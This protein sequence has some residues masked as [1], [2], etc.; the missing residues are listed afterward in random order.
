MDSTRAKL[1]RTLSDF[2]YGGDG[3]SHGELDQVFDDFD[4]EVAGGSKRDRVR[5]AV[6]VCPESVL[7]RLVAGLVD[8]LNR[9]GLLT[10]PGADSAAVARLQKRLLPYNLRIAEDGELVGGTRLGIEPEAMIDVPALREHIAR[11]HL[12]LETD[13]SALMLGSSKELL[14]STGKL[15]LAGV[16]EEPPAKFPGLL[17]RALEVLGL[18]AKAT[19]GDDDVAAATRKILGGLQQIG[20]GVNELRN[21]H[22]TG[23]GRAN[24]VKLGLRQSRLAAGS[25]V[26]LASVMID[27]LE[28]PNAPW[29]KKSAET[30]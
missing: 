27:T 11:I 29:R 1:A 9:L 14:E 18:H 15:V 28:D 16:G 17:T 3:P 10:A 26:V 8:L 22:G 7:P 2:W 20:L 30:S 23:H 13:D 6:E 24:G 19:T 25:A 21:D 5:E 4:L 12:A